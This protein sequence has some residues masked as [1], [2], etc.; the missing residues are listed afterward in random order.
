MP[1]LAFASGSDAIV[2]LIHPGRESAGP[3]FRPSHFPRTDKENPMS[4]KKP[5]S[6]NTSA[7]VASTAAKLLSNPRTPA[8]VKSVAASAL[9][10]RP[11]ASKS[12]GR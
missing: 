4:S 9:T 1:A 8:S 10:Q 12:K 7:R 5:T 2:C 6:E 3:D 11:S